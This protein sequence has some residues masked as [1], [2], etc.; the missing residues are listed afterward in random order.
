MLG[1]IA[2]A[3]YV[4]AGLVMLGALALGVSGRGDQLAAAVVA[5]G[6]LKETFA[7]PVT[8]LLPDLSPEPSQAISSSTFG[9]RLMSLA[10]RGMSLALS[11]VSSLSSGVGVS[12]A[13]SQ[14]SSLAGSEGS[15]EQAMLTVRESAK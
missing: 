9:P 5:A 15:E 11:R 7:H 3:V 6:N 4:L 13:S 12:R 14:R 2:A 10:A 8:T 1:V